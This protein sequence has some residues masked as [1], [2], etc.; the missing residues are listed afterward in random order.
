M[1]VDEASANIAVGTSTIVVVAMDIAVWRIGGGDYCC[2]NYFR[3]GDDYFHGGDDYFHGG[4]DYFRGGDN[5]CHGSGYCV[6][7]YAAV[8]MLVGSIWAASCTVIWTTH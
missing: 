8:T 7:G 5:N 1:V 3:G 4:H 2:I 6:G